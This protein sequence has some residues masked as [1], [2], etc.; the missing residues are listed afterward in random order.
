MKKKTI[1]FCRHI[2]GILLCLIL[3]PAVI[4]AQDN[5]I[6]GTVTD[7]KSKEPLIGVSVSEK[8]TTNGTITDING[9]FSINA[10]IGTVLVFNYL[11][12]E[13]K[14]IQASSNSLSIVLSES[15]ELLDEVV[16]I[17]YGIQRKSV[18][19]AAISSVKADD[20]GKMAP[21]R[22]ENILK[23]QV[24]G[25]QII[26]NSG[27]PGA[28]SKVRIRGIGT[29]NNS[30]PLYIVD[31]MAVGGGINNINPTDIESIEVLKDAAS[32]AVYGARAANGVILI[33]TKAGKQG[34]T[35]IN[36]D[37]SYGL[38]NP[39]K[40]KSVLDGEQYMIMRNEMSIN[41]GG[42]AI[43]SPDDF[44]ALKSG[45]TPNT[46]WQEEVF[47]KN[48]P[49]VNHQF[50][51]SGG[52][53]KGA[54]FLSLGYFS[55]EG[56]VGGNY[57]VSNFDRWSIR[58]NNNYEVLNAVNDR[59]YLNKVKVGMNISYARSKSVGVPG[60]VN[61][62]FGSVLGSAIGLTPLM[63]VY[64][65]E[66]EAE[67]ILKSYPFAVKDKNGQVF[68]LPPEGFREIVNPMALLNRP[69]RVKNSEDKFIGTFYAELDVLKGLKFKSSYGFDLAFWG[70]DMYRFPYYLSPITNVSTE[71]QSSVSSEMNR[72]FT[73]QLENTLTYNFS[74]DKKHNFTIL[75]GQSAQ[76]YKL[77]NL[78]GQDFDLIAFDPYMAVINSGTADRSDERTTGYTSIS[79]LASYFGRIDYNFNERY[80]LQATVRRDGS[81]KFG[82]NNKWGTFPSF[83]FG[84]NALNEEFMQ[85]V[86]PW[87]FDQMKLRFSWG[88]NGNQ[89]I[90]AFAYADLLE[91]G[92]NYYYG[93]GENN[94]RM[95]FGTSSSRIPN[96]NLKWEESKQTN[97]G[98]D[99][100][101]LNN[102]LSFTFDYFQ[103][104]TNGMLKEQPIPGYVGKR[105]PFANAGKMENKG[106]EFDL[107]YRFSVRDF[108]F[109]I[110]GNASFV[111]QKLID[112]G[113]ATGQEQWG[114]SGAAGVDDFIFAR[115]GMV[116]P[117][118]YGWIT[119]GLLQT[120]AEADAY[121]AKFGTSADPGDVRFLDLNN[122]NLID[123]RDRDMIGC[124]LPD[125]TYGL[126]IN[127]E[128]K[129]FD[130]TMFFQ[131]VT[132]NDIFD[133]SQR[134]DVG[135]IN[136]P[137]WIMERWTGPGTS[138]RIPRLTSNDRNRNWRVSDLYVKSGDYCRLKNI[139]LG[140]TLPASFSRKAGVE[141]L[142]LHIGAENLFTWTK[143]KDGFDP[144]IGE[145]NQREMGV[146]KGLYPQ[147][148]TVT[149][150][151][152]ISF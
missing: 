150:G 10:P 70:A 148:R 135:G 146:D 82:P 39:W 22:V 18:V 41:G 30:D 15:T 107:G 81:D 83:S 65:N 84:W 6:S 106:V 12:Y 151:A 7:A 2:L 35:N 49:I 98:A 87:W 72:G 103:K 46:D 86:K 89:A 108:N 137:A 119:D 133:I 110:N 69:E 138:N 23:G 121:N 130:L 105:A 76:K 117:F 53:D 85:N 25:V 66:K 104:K 27:Q 56:I 152:S 75:L 60:G 54:Y 43:Y 37:F 36:Y 109:G 93:V 71:A 67:A 143:Y 52:N 122:D 11:G 127:T 141:R 28:D 9:H 50:S 145:G 58:S 112:L 128:W 40:K 17:G 13:G 118:F 100:R 96:P 1:T 140:Y 74:L 59:S 8:G 95:I 38:Q 24:S 149:F 68:Q 102:A 14:E 3:F 44:T 16:V 94:Q 51:V 131:G 139:Q 126:T 101:F 124:G 88:I 45:K 20:L 62:E 132:G 116:Y 4:Q 144:E 55:Q 26:S 77:R 113:N 47:N 32:A 21:S 111:K 78:F 136:R 64:A 63:S 97:I 120:K 31:G 5:K 129:D 61:S 147:A 33:T 92:Q 99:F 48:A 90:E 125:W 73:W 29:V 79:T 134:A 142:R 123:D 42:S 57:G 34:K 115:N 19:T 114:S 91:G 80:M